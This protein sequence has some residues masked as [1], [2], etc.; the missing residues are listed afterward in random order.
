VRAKKI[1]DGNSQSL[2]VYTTRASL[3]IFTIWS[4]QY[5][6]ISWTRISRSVWSAATFTR[7]ICKKKKSQFYNNS[8]YAC[9]LSLSQTRQLFASVRKNLNYMRIEKLTRRAGG[10]SYVCEKSNTQIDG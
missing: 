9:R 4:G 6:C 7:A 10:L 2:K 3:K 5:L 1:G 8:L